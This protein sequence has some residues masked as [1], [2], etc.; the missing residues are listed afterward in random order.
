LF[1]YSRQFVVA[2]ILTGSLGIWLGWFVGESVLR[3][4]VLSTARQELTPWHLGTAGSSVRAILL[5]A[6]IFVW[7]ELLIAAYWQ[8]FDFAFDAKPID[9]RLTE[10]SW[11][12]FAG[13]QCESEDDVLDQ[14][15]RK[16]LLF[17]PVGALLTLALPS[18]LKRP[19]KAIVLLGVLAV[20]VTLEA[21]QLF[22]PTHGPG[23]SDIL[24]GLFGGWIGY[25]L[26]TRTRSFRPA[27]GCAAPGVFSRKANP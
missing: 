16:T 9:E 24:I 26:I 18:A 5:G 21:G 25:V 22:L 20:A 4:P 10:V 3:K 15:V 7:L 8:P 17:I 6:A 2:D 13:Y 11:V 23:V 14:F 19:T 12:P 1:V 27:E